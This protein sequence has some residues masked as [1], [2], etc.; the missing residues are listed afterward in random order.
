MLIAHWPGVDLAP[1]NRRHVGAM[2]DLLAQTID[3][4]G[5]VNTGSTDG[6]SPE[7]DAEETGLRPDVT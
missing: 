4:D 6:D 5:D 1:P 3:N 2:I 7:A